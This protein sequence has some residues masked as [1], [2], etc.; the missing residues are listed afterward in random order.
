M[1]PR[2]REAQESGLSSLVHKVMDFPQRLSIGQKVLSIHYM[3]TGQLI[4]QPENQY[5][6]TCI[7]D[8]THVSSIKR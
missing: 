6:L 3:G 7:I 5:V 8:S 4:F 1:S 2:K